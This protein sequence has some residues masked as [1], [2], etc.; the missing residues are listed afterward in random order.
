[1]KRLLLIVLTLL[2]IIGCGNSSKN[3]KELKSI[4]SNLNKPS[5][6]DKINT[7]KFFFKNH[8]CFFKIGLIFRTFFCFYN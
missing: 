3:Q 5:K 4:F 6:I 7:S 8:K 2:L 1:M